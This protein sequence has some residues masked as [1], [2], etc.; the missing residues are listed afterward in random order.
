MRE[1]RTTP[2]SPRFRRAALGVLLLLAVGCVTFTT[3][4]VGERDLAEGV[5]QVKDMA[6]GEQRAVPLESLIEELVR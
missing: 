5:A 4:V 3:V 2:L 6:S 1:M